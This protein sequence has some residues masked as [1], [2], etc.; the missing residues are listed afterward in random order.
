MRIPLFYL[1][2]FCGT[3]FADYAWIPKSRNLNLRTGWEFFK[4]DHNFD[5]EGTRNPL[6]TNGSPSYL[7]QNRFFLESEYGLIDHWA[8]I[9]RT[10]VLTAQINRE[11]D[12]QRL[13]SNSGLFD[14]ALGF[15][16]QIAS[17]S[18][19]LTVE[20]ALILPPYS[21]E[22]LSNQDLALGDGV[23]G[24]LLQTHAGLKRGRFAFSVSPGLLFRFEG[25]SHQ[26]VLETAVSAVIQRFFLRI[27]QTGSFALTKN[28]NSLL[29]PANP[30]IGSGGSYSR[31]SIAPDLISLGARFGFH[32][33]KKFRLET[34]ASQT[35]WG[36]SAGDGLKLGLS[37]VS[38]FDFFVPDN[39]EPI[40]EVP[41]QN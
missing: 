6:T 32:V 30:E 14:T 18:P 15:K 29:D 41:L 13:L 38:N 1:L 9:L 37:L 24:V 4:S 26:A 40:Q 2:L 27:Y 12:G 36:Q 28:P 17:D 10:S 16:W 3:V 34:F 19:L 33:S 8:G 23:Y 39:R 7:V 21:N 11:S 20:S 5:G 35:V 31:L 25:F 22:K